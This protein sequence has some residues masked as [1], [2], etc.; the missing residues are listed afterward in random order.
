MKKKGKF[1]KKLKAYSAVAAGTLLLAPSA[2]AA[3]VYSGL[4]NIQISAA[5]N[6]EGIDLN[7]DGVDD[8]RIGRSA[9]GSWHLWM[10]LQTNGVSN[11]NESLRYD[12]ARL[13]TGYLIQST[14]PGPLYW[15][16][17]SSETLAGTFTYG[18]TLTAG[19][20][21]STAGC[22][23]V[24]FNTVAGAPRFGWIYLDGTLSASRMATIV[25]W[26]YEDQGASILSGA[27]GPA[28]TCSPPAPTVSV[29]TL[30]QWGLIL[31]IGLLAGAGVTVLRKQE[32]A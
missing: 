7:N 25:D 31:L 22:I 20:F 11:I 23:G 9:T 8:F 28:G 19:N 1:E 2:N 30:N 6:S 13:D 18:G 29:P 12:P 21:N 10:S 15:S 27:G 26:A 17:D 5:N 16:N 24:R 3:V 32:K 4:Q 14:L